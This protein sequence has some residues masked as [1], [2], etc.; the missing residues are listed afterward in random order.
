MWMDNDLY[1]GLCNYIQL[2]VGIPVA[3]AVEHDISNTKVWTLEFNSQGM[4]LLIIYVL[5]AMLSRFG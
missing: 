5:K 3:Q 2:Y 4:D 1:A